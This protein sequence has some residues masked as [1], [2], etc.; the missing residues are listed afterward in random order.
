MSKVQ[1]A[2]ALAERLRDKGDGRISADGAKAVIEAM[3]D[4]ALIELLGSGEFVFPGL[5]KLKVKTKPSRK[6]VNPRTG[7]KLVI[8][9]H[10]VVTVKTRQNVLEALNS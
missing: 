2:K 9:E 4:V 1:L 6:G 3:A 7:E 5:C 8:A 10:K